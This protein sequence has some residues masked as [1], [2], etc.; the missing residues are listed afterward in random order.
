MA[1]RCV[2]NKCTF[3][4]KKTGEN[5]LEAVMLA[6]QTCADSGVQ[7]QLPIPHPTHTHTIDGDYCCFSGDGLDQI[8]VSYLCV[9]S[10]FSVLWPVH[11]QHTV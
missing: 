11:Q 6:G 2:Y 3:L 7:L 9:P 4:Q 8:T 5:F 1:V 10:Y